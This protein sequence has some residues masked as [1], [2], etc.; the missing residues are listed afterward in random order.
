MSRNSFYSP[1]KNKPHTI[2]YGRLTSSRKKIP[3]ARLINISLSFM[4]RGLPFHHTVSRSAE[5]ETVLPSSRTYVMVIM[6]LTMGADD[7]VTKPVTPLELLAR[8]NSQR[9]RYKRGLEMV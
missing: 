3:S 6:G 9:R 4:A 8:V 7:Y 2:A 1:G 5:T